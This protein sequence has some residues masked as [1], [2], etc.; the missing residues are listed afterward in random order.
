MVA[1]DQARPAPAASGP[2]DS[3]RPGRSPDGA[4]GADY[5]KTVLTPRTD[6][7]MKA[8]LP[9]REPQI[10]AFWEQ[11]QMYRKLQ[12][13]RRAQ[14][15]PRFV[16]HDGPPY[17]NGHIH[18]GTALNKILKD[19]IVRVRSMEGMWAPYVPGWDTHGLP[20]EH[21]VIR[22]TG[23]DRRQVPVVEFRR[24]C[25]EYA[26]QF[27]EIQRQEFKR[28]GVWGDWERPYLTLEP[29]YEAR[30]VEL[31]GRMASRG[32]IYRGLKPV[33]WC[34]RCETALAE[35]EVEYR[36][37]RSPSIY[38]L[39]PV[40]ESPAVL[41]P[42][43]G[44]AQAEAPVRGQA[45]EQAQA[46][47]VIWTTTP[48]TLPANQAVAVHPDHSYV[49][50]EVAGRVLVVAEPRL[51]A[52]ARL[53]GEG[54]VR[55][56]RRL[57]GFE[58]L[59]AFLG[60]PLDG[61]LVPVVG[62][63]MVSME[64]GSG[65]VHIAPGH[66][67]EDYEVG[68]RYQL[69]VVNPVDGQGRFTDQAGPYA[70]LPVEEANPVIIGDLRQAGR[71]WA[72]GEVEHQY[73][74]CW[75]C[76]GPV[77]FRATEQWFA[78]IDGFRRRALE[79]IDRVEWVPSWGRERIRRMVAERHDW[80]IS[81]QRSWGVP[82][83]V[84]YCAGCRRPLVD[85]TVIAAVAELF[86]REGSDAWFVRPAHEILPA[87]T[88]CPQCGGGQFE[89]E[90]DTMD[91]W[92]DSGSSH[93]AVLTTRPELHW[94]ADLYVEGTDQHRGW[95]QS[96]L[97]TAVATRGEAPYRMVLTHG[98]V[99][100]G[101]GRAMHKSLG[102]VILPG[103][104]IER[105][106]ADVL[107]LL[108]ASS[109]YREDLRVSD[110]IL[111]Q[112]ADAYRRIRNTARFLLGNLQDFAPTRDAV[113]LEQLEVLDRWALWRTAQLARRCTEA[114]RR[115]E[116]HV[117]YHELVR[118][119][120]VELGGF[121]LDVLKDRLYCEAQDSPRRRSAQTA[122]YHILRVLVGLVAPVLVHTAE[123]IWQHMP[124]PREADSVHLTTW[125]DVSA[126]ENLGPAEPVELFLQARR[127]ALKALE[128]ARQAGELQTSWQ[129]EVH[130]QGPAEATARLSAHRELLA[131]WLMAAAVYLD[132]HGPAAQPDQAVARAS[133][134]AWQAWVWR[135]RLARCAR[136]RR[137]LPSVGQEQGFADL[138][139]RCARVLARR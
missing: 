129:A 99:V 117:P 77:L 8:D 56:L 106:G 135:T 124:E 96:S 22:H 47:V 41:A 62:D 72:A 54:P 81:R 20:I 64:E 80:C 15:A 97:L 108:V 130:L 98:F 111:E 132:G 68:L 89:K 101:Q 29:E 93:E 92:F 1:P 43:G 66:G 90:T 39:F 55:V 26:L 13:L 139:G 57:R 45:P 87:G 25:K 115:L 95:F 82:I 109:D 110:E 18:L 40:R 103:Q 38:V 73:P 27:V 94:P 50:A 58:L 36:L 32:Y 23:L 84:F 121:Y 34:P 52:V 126:W 76:K 83:P 49:V 102:N 128:N 114:Y 85:E 134:G 60:H 119:C 91:V 71:L 86:R 17:A 59:G 7:P 33:Y 123:E 69:P 51:E 112:V 24:R 133:E 105:F 46:E 6:F 70:G 122:L 120:T 127:A 78:S 5:S 10:Q 131:E 137:H 3:A 79:A 136:C 28:L 88:R 53:A 67:Q 11:H 63:D 116:F 21:E 65:C 100:D 30:Q 31:F 9:R 4:Q 75:R 35:A 74:H 16:L 37:K 138:C 104:V 61:R 2:A 19:F 118:F 14:G 42:A 125:P 44:P 107:R 113:A 48:W 12:E